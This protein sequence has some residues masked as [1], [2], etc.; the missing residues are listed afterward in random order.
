MKGRWYGRGAEL[1]GQRRG[2]CAGVRSAATGARSRQ[3]AS[4]CANGAARTASEPTERARSGTRVCTTSRFR[5]RNRFRSWRCRAATRGSSRRTKQP[6]PKRLRELES[7][8]ATRVRQGGANADRVTGNLA[9]AVYHHDTSRELDPQ[10]H[11]HAVAANL[12]WDGTEGRW[13]ALQASGIY[14][15][16]AYLTEIYRNALAREVRALGYEIE[17]QRDSKGR[18]CGFEIRGRPRRNC[19]RSSASGAA[20]AMLRSAPSWRRTGASP[21]TTRSPFWFANRAPTS[22]IEISHGGVALASA[23]A[24]YYGG[25]SSA[26]QLRRVAAARGSSGG[27]ARTLAAIRRG[28]HLR[29]RFR[30]SG[31]RNADGS[32]ASWAGTNRA[33]N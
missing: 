6:S 31:S 15:R 24:T 26:R 32:S 5:R 30:C 1:L 10:L 16:R 19:W 9:L 18:D 33:A 20:S 3:P 14:E 11:T 29:A 13:K 8:A 28:A 22:S 27:I 23:A 25:E 2:H 17:N 7:L 12:T 4:F 21:A